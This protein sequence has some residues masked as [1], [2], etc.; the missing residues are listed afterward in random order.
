MNTILML[1]GLVILVADCFWKLGDAM[2]PKLR[3]RQ[4]RVDVRENI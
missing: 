3:R 1:T 2:T 4:I